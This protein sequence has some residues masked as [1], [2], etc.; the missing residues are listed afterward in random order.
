M[1][2]LMKTCSSIGIG[3]SWLGFVLPKGG[4]EAG[5]SRGKSSPAHFAQAQLA[6]QVRQRQVKV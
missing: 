5:A 1:L 3:G 6:M 2:I 4:F